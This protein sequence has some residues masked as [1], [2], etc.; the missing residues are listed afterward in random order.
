MAQAQAEKPKPAENS[1]GGLPESRHNSEHQKTREVE[2]RIE[3]RG[4]MPR[5]FLRGSQGRVPAPFVSGSSEVV[6]FRPDED[7]VS[8]IQYT[9]HGDSYYKGH[10]TALPLTLPVS[11]CPQ[12]YD[13]PDEVQLAEGKEKESEEEIELSLTLEEGDEPPT[14]RC[15]RFQPFYSTHEAK[16]LH[17]YE[18]FVYFI[19]KTMTTSKNK[20]AISGPVH[21]TFVPPR[22]GDIEKIEEGLPK[23]CTSS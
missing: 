5:R 23:T 7:I 8:D 16:T 12:E 2:G 18:Y 13:G 15:H 1:G 20:K 22:D 21:P 9:D 14:H 4:E 17:L 11:Q 19:L 6:V 10:L 3:E